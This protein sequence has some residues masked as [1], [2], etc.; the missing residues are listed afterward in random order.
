MKCLAS[1]GGGIQEM[2]YSVKDFNMLVI[3]GC[4]MDC[5]KLTMGKNELN[6]FCHLRLTDMGYSKGQTPASDQV[7]D[8]IVTYAISLS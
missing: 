7:I 2:I 4:P 8:E 5:G 6:D 1:I 3:D